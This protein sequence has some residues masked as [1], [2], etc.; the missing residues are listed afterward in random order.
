[1]NERNF[2]IH[3]DENSNIKK[4]EI[5][6]NELNED[7][8][9]NLPKNINEIEY[10]FKEIK[11]IPLSIGTI[12]EQC[13]LYLSNYDF[14]FFDEQRKEYFNYHFKDKESELFKQ[15]EKDIFTSFGELYSEFSLVERLEISSTKLNSIKP[16]Y[17]FAFEMSESLKTSSFVKKKIN[18][19]I[20]IKN[21]IL[22]NLDFDKKKHFNS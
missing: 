4:D 5:N 3:S 1:M 12:K 22:K 21:D 16:N 11:Y 18:D 15:L 8:G 17:S 6:S 9:Y 19:Y 10:P 2:S 7:S 13:F 14:K 20:Y